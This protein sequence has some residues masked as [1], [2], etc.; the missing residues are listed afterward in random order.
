MSEFE[1]NPEVENRVNQESPKPDFHKIFLSHYDPEELTDLWNFI[2]RSEYGQHYFLKGLFLE[3]GI[4]PFTQPDYNEA[5]K[6]YQKGAE[7]RDSYCCF[8]LHYIYKKDYELFQLQKDRYLEMLYLIQ[9]AAY[10]DEKDNRIK[11][12]FLDPVMHLAVHLDHEDPDLIKCIELLEKYENTDESTKNKARFLR[13]W[14]CIRFTL[15]D[16][17]K[18]ECLHNMTILADEEE[19]ESC[20]FLGEAYKYGGDFKQN[21]DVSKKY[22]GIAKKYNC[23]KAIETLG[24]I[25]QVTK[26]PELSIENY[27]LGAKF[28]SYTSLKILGEYQIVG[29]FINKNFDEGMKNI[30]Y[31]YLQCD[32]WAML[33]L[34]EVYK[35]HELKEKGNTLIKSKMYKIAK[36]LYDLK[37]KIGKIAHIRLAYNVYAECFEKGYDVPKDT[38]KAMQI[39]KES[40]R[41][42]EMEKLKTFSYYRIARIYEKE[43]KF[44]EANQN[45]DACVRACLMMIEDQTIVKNQAYFYLLG[46]LF[47]MGR[48]TPRNLG[49]SKHYLKEGIK[50]E[51]FFYFGSIFS[52]KCQKLLHEISPIFKNIQFKSSSLV[53]N[54]QP[55]TRTCKLES[56]K[57]L[58]FEVY[59]GSSGPIKFFL[60]KWKDQEVRLAEFHSCNPKNYYYILNHLLKLWNI[61]PDYLEQ[62]I[63]IAADPKTTE[64]VAIFKKLPSSYVNIQDFFEMIDYLPKNLPTTKG[65]EVYWCRAPVIDQNEEVILTG[66]DKIAPVDKLEICRKLASAIKSLHSNNLTHGNLNPRNIYISANFDVVLTEFCLQDPKLFLDK[67][68]YNKEAAS[69]YCYNYS[70]PEY[71]TKGRELNLSSD[72]WSLGCLIY[73]IYEERHPLME[74]KPQDILQLHKKKS[75]ITL[76]FAKGTPEQIRELVQK[77]IRFQTEDRCDIS[78]IIQTLHKITCP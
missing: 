71:F 19:I 60:G 72:I 36:K 29:K 20:C 78:Y 8:R 49:K 75:T 67:E 42:I 15:S 31:A 40:L 54:S 48:G 68:E 51:N 70:P 16:H 55:L 12:K 39:L 74:L 17:T 32:F 46:K 13:N 37:D 43:G 24:Y 5:L 33:T 26:R 66:A 59:T 63:G 38:E 23:V 25:H 69:N 53:Q 62:L 45:Y 77:C 1:D 18:L 27:T 65:C 41:K 21:L 10:F 2:L 6:H 14:C 28:G 58:K 57:D 22:L 50:M 56:P 34:F 30:Y 7:L 3:H 44:E 4:H 76:E 64:V 61:K 73:Y 35:Y 9:A 52:K 47:Y 11:R